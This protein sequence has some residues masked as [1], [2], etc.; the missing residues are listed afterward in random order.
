MD[1][2]NSQ[3]R[4]CVP[5]SWQGVS[6]KR[7]GNIRSRDSCSYTK[8]LLFKVWQKKNPESFHGLWTKL[9][10]LNLITRFHKCLWQ[11]PKLRFTR[12]CLETFTADSWSFSQRNICGYFFTFQFIQLIHNEQTH[13]PK[14]LF[15]VENTNKRNCLSYQL[16]FFSLMGIP[17][18][19]F[20]P[21]FHLRMRTL[22][23]NIIANHKN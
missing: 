5:G 16:R 12:Y 13:T 14:I 9:Q 2:C 8:F 23:K 3:S 15:T 10:W 22:F 18:F 4:A 6:G 1:W 19:I 21:R 17:W 11:F 20:N 7:G